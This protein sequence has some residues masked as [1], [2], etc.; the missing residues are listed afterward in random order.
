MTL[1]D[2]GN[3]PLSDGSSLLMRLHLEGVDIGERAKDQARKWEQHNDDFVSLFYDGHNAFTTLLAG[4]RAANAKLLDNMREYVKDADRSGWNK[5]VTAR[6]GIPLVEGI[7][8]YMDGDF[9]AATDKLGAIMPEL[10][11]KIQGSKAQKDIFRQILLHAALKSVDKAKFAEAERILQETLVSGIN[12]K[13][14]P[15][16]QRFLDKLMA[17]HEA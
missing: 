12:T 6:V 9:A 7:N 2:G 10:Q 8:L 1:K 15:L 13:H 16:N 11:Q 5:D 14:T 4:D 3:F 17:A